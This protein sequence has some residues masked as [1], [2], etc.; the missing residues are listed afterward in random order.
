MLDLWDSTWLHS[1]LK[2][3]LTS[4]DFIIRDTIDELSPVMSMS[5]NSIFKYDDNVA[6]IVEN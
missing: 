1:K 2:T 6:E 5:E 4:L 3:K